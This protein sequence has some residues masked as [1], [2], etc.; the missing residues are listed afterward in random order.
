MSRFDI[1]LAASIRK[2]R[3]S[4]VEVSTGNEN[5]ITDNRLGGVIPRNEKPV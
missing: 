4:V 3:G 2:L 1:A 5:P